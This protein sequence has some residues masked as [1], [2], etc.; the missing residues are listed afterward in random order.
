MEQTNIR[1]LAVTGPTAVGKTAFAIAL[2][3]AYNG[4]I[5]S[6]DSMQIYRGMDIGTAKATAEEQAAVPHH[7]I[8]I[9]D[10]S[11]LYSA[12]DYAKDALA[13]ARDIVSRGKLP[14]FCGGTGLYLEAVRTGRHETDAVS[15]EAYRAELLRIAEEKGNGVLHEMLTKVDAQAAEIIHQNNVKRVIRALE[16]Y[17]VTGKTKTQLDKESESL[18]PQIEL[19]TFC[20]CFHDREALY[21]RIDGR[22][23]AMMKE[24]LIEEVRALYGK[25][26][27][28][29]ALQAIGYKELFAVFDGKDSYEGATEKIKQASRRYAKRQLTWFL[30]K[31]HL[32]LYRDGEDGTLIST[33]A[34]L[35]QAAPTV[36]AFLEK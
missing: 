8:D 15:D 12:A 5:I 23:D 18:P 17:H 31:P 6:C 35:G 27:S 22:V 29:T 26:L 21:R 11:A 30:A 28:G 3:K 14:I 25:P 2:A 20:L 1:A 13:V 36:A 24:G 7:M 4:E 19:S 9:C 32:P 34:L 10:P 33:E 16:V